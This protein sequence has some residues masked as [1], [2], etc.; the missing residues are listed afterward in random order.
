MVCGILVPRPGT[1]PGTP[2]VEVWSP[3]H[4][5]TR[6]VTGDIRD[7]G[8][9]PGSERSPGG[10]HGN[11]LQYFCL[12]NLMNRGARGAKFHELAESD[13]MT[14]PPPLYVTASGQFF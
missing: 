14:K 7:M 13:V 3:K 11:P 12:G 10:G 1:E 2:A 8:S 6:K 9:I 4:W 5:T